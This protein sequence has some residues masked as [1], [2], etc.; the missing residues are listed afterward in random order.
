MSN[1]FASVQRIARLFITGSKH[2]QLPH[3]VALLAGLAS[4]LEVFAEQ[5]KLQIA[6]ISCTSH[7]RTI[8]D[9]T[10][11]EGLQLLASLVFDD[12]GLERLAQLSVNQYW[13][14]ELMR[15]CTYTLSS[16]A[17]DPKTGMLSTDAIERAMFY[18]WSSV[19]GD[20]LQ[21]VNT[22]D[23]HLLSQEEMEA[24]KSSG[25]IVVDI[26]DPE[27]D[28]L[29]INPLFQ[30]DRDSEYR[31]RT[32]MAFDKH[33]WEDPLKVRMQ[34]YD[35]IIFLEQLRQLQDGGNGSDKKPTSSCPLYVTCRSASGERS[36]YT[37]YAITG[38]APHF[39]KTG[40]AS[41][42][43]G[44]ALSSYEVQMTTMEVG[45][46]YNHKVQLRVEVEERASNDCI[47]VTE[48]IVPNWAYP[49][50]AGLLTTKNPN[51]PLP[52][53]LKKTL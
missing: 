1:R 8:Q 12:R 2:E 45:P 26:I 52:A 21:K 17:V 50:L 36:H 25:M 37:V 23:F 6:E 15:Y 41:G 5:S 31:H 44:G 49:S 20:L 38:G 10:D 53:S 16:S 39:G 47:V 7:T 33:L 30:T 34:G 40:D 13:L 11:N 19:N 29:Y 27:G 3:R 14:T 28:Q 42:Q 4:D 48:M 24:A 51:W 22:G 43:N 18:I 32:F 35:A 9:L 46:D